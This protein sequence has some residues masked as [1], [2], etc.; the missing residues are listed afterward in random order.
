MKPTQAELNLK[1]ESF[2][3]NK[4]TLMNNWI[5]N[6]FSSQI[7]H[8]PHDLGTQKMAATLRLDWVFHNDTNNTFSGLGVFTASRIP[9]GTKVMHWQGEVVSKVTVKKTHGHICS[10]LCNVDGTRCAIDGPHSILFNDAP[11]DM[12]QIYQAPAPLMLLTN[13]SRNH[14][15]PNCCKV[16]DLYTARECLDDFMWSTTI[17]LETTRDIEIG[18]KFV[19]DCP[20][21]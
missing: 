2:L 12:N 21:C 20:V 9:S 5:S 13:S 14:K 3:N 7:I 10:H 15:N 18:E 17:C 19:W 16:V 11:P 4:Q 1:K 6:A 8:F